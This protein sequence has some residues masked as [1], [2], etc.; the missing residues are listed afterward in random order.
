MK[1]TTLLAAAFATL[2]AGSP[3]RRCT[4]TFEEVKFP[5]GKSNWVGG[6]GLYPTCV[7]A[8]YHE[9]YSVKT[10]EAMI[11]FA[12][13]ECQRLGCVSF[14]VL[15]AVPQDPPERN[16]YVTLFGGYPTTPQDYVQDETKSEAV[17]DSRA[18]NAVTNC[19]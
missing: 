1:T 12:Q 10:Q 5:E 17:Q 13:Q 4:T 15:S 2:A 18:F 9:D 11:Q 7:M 14:M 6:P 3:T 19:S 16:W 8:V